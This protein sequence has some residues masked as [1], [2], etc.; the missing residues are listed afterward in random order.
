MAGGVP[1]NY[2]SGSENIVASYSFVDIVSKTGIIT[3]YGAIDQDGNGILTTSTVASDVIQTVA[4]V[5]NDV[6]TKVIDKDFDVVVNRPLTLSGILTATIPLTLYELDQ[7]TYGYVTVKLRKWNGTIET[8]IANDTSA[9]MT[10]TDLAVFDH[11]NVML[12]RFTVPSTP[13]K[14]G[15]TL[16]ITLEVFG[17]NIT[18]GD[19][20]IA[21]AHD[22]LG[23]ISAL[24]APVQYFTGAMETQMVVNIPVKIEL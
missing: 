5:D 23:R 2:R 24:T 11:D 15:E 20:K 13:F 17:K 9:E 1:V 12:V 14:T 4:D 19:H 18:P 6:F 3:F 22:P 21:I 8:E 7:T 10:R 16:R